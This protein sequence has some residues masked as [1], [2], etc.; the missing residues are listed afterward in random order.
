MS[1]CP[2]F[3]PSVRLSGCL[4]VRPV[5]YLPFHFTGCWT[6][7]DVEAEVFVS[8]DIS[9]SRAHIGDVVTLVCRIVDMPPDGFIYWFK[10]VVADDQDYVDLLAASSQPLPPYDVITRMKFASVSSGTS[11]TFTL[12]IGGRQPKST[13]SRYPLTARNLTTTAWWRHLASQSSYRSGPVTRCPLQLSPVYVDDEEITRQF[14]YDTSTNVRCQGGSAAKSCPLHYLRSAKALGS[15]SFTGNQDGSSLIVKT[16][17]TGSGFESFNRTI[18]LIINH[19]PLFKCLTQHTARRDGNYTLTC[20]I[21]GRPSA[22]LFYW[23][24]Y[25]RGE[26]TEAWPGS[27]VDGWNAFASV[28]QEDL[29]TCLVSLTLYN[30]SDFHYTNYELVVGNTVGNSSLNITLFEDFTP[31]AGPNSAGYTISNLLGIVFLTVIALLQSSN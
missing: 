17:V 28:D 24:L 31:T 25:K 4:S 3:C 9:Q 21:H 11:R 22:D 12:T 7:N 29:N 18:P 2:S 16:H 23:R 15:Y 20:S 14:S 1:V 10:R 6:Q 5:T 26:V 30:L 27:F 8:I 13:T 19:A